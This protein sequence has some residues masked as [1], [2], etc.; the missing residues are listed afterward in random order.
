MLQT[1]PEDSILI[2]VR[3]LFVEGMDVSKRILVLDIFILP[4]FWT[5]ISDGW[6]IILDRPSKLEAA[7]F[8]AGSQGIASGTQQ[9]MEEGSNTDRL[10]RI[11]CC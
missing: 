8:W 11:S 4:I 5:N 2:K 10:S 6:S 1:K 7:C 3:V 9:K